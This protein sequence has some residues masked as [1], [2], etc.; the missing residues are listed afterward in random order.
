MATGAAVEQSQSVTQSEEGIFQSIRALLASRFRVPLADVRPESDLVC[1]LGIDWMDAEDL[2]LLLEE[3]FE[4]DI[5]NSDAECI[6]TVDDAV[7]C[8]LR[9]RAS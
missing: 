8:V 9:S 7:K 1:D 2:P 3:A 5:S 4:I 6:S